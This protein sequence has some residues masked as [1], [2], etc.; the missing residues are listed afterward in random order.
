MDELTPISELWRAR[1]PQHVL[2]A[3]RAWATTT[4]EVERIFGV[5]SR[6]RGV[7]KDGDALGD[8]DD[9]DLAIQLAS[10]KSSPPK[11]VIEDWRSSLSIL[12]A[13]HVDLHIHHQGSEIGEPGVLLFKRT[14]MRFSEM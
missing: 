4:H 13:F 5:G 10:E 14:P 3:I 11:E 9:L 12:T 2:K 7:A 1:P 8:R 6:F